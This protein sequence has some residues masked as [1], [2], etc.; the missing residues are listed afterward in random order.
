MVKDMTWGRTRSNGATIVALGPGA[1]LTLQGEFSE[2]FPYIDED[3]EL[4]GR[5]R[6]GSS[7]QGVCLWSPLRADA[8]RRR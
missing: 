1:T 6:G 7:E 8:P 2:R 3:E 4:M 5:G